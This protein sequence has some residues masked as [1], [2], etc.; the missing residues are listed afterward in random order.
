MNQATEKGKVKVVTKS[1][2]T[3]IVNNIINQG[4]DYFGIV[5]NNKRIPIDTTINT[6]SFYLRM[7]SYH[8]DKYY[9]I[10]VY[11]KDRDK[12]HPA[13]GYLYEVKDSSILI[14]MENP[15]KKKPE[16]EA[17]TLELQISNMDKIK[18]RRIGNV[19]TGAVVGLA[20][21]VLPLL[22]VGGVEEWLYWYMITVPVAVG[23][24]LIG[25]LLGSIKKEYKID[26]KIEQYS[27][28]RHELGNRAFIKQKE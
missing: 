25:G 24:A 11:L 1:G 22:F 5:Y 8:H 15:T 23:T 20:I 28:H 2:K 16:V 26:G 17:S 6:Y 21:G 19:A 12:N 7:P 18:L 3:V 27:I 13:I 4:G 9:R 10:W 14:S